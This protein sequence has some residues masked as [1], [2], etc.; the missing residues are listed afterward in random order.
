MV[1]AVTEMLDII[2]RS[3]FQSLYNNAIPR[4]QKTL[5]P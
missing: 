5:S 3:Q 2:N 1:I 4:P